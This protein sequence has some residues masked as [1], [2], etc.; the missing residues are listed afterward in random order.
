MN[1]KL[2]AIQSGMLIL[3]AAG[4]DVSATSQDGYISFY[5]DMT[6]LS[7][8]STEILRRLDWVVNNDGMHLIVGITR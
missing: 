6:K 1:D 5:G 8:I 4:I 7:G 3:E 2:T